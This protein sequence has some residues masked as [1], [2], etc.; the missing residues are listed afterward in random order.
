MSSP[1]A[2]TNGAFEPA[3]YRKAIADMFASLDVAAQREL[4][5]RIA[6]L[7]RHIHAMAMKGEIAIDLPVVRRAAF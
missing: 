1:T 7:P 5:E 4:V 3:A 6:I 2:R